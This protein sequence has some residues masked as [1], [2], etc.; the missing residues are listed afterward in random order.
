MA[1]RGNRS[2]GSRGNRSGGN[3]TG[4]NR[5]GGNRTGGNRT[6][7]N[8]TGGNRTGGNRTGGSG[9]NRNVQR[10][11]SQIGVGTP[12]IR[13]HFDGTF[14]TGVFLGFSNGSVVINQD[15]VPRFIKVTA[16]TAVDVGV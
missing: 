7:G 1:S 9:G 12:N 11:L 15:G 13:I 6:G 14:H 16:V 2:G 3:R 10:I 8:R 4:G 5:T